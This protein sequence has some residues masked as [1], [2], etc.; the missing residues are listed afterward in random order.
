MKPLLST[1]VQYCIFI[2]CNQMMES[3]R[4]W[5][6]VQPTM[7]TSHLHTRVVFMSIYI[8]IYIQGLTRGIEQLLVT[9]TQWYQ[10]FTIRDITQSHWNKTKDKTRKWE[11]EKKIIFFFCSFSLKYKRVLFG[12]IT[13]AGLHYMEVIGRVTVECIQGLQ[14]IT[15]YLCRPTDQ[16]CT[17]TLWYTYM[18]TCCDCSL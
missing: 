11:R 9:T 8:Y 5:D 4:T 13:P 17:E 1:C 14:D 10:S 12:F 18:L 7:V 3:G 6:P 2:T 15:S 16:C